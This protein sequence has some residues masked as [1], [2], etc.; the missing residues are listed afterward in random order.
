MYGLEAISANNGWA[1]AF[2]GA[3]IV[4][5]GL[6]FLSF[7]ISRLHK[8]LN[9][10]EERDMVYLRLKTM[11]RR[12]KKKTELDAKLEEHNPAETA[13]QFKM[14]AD[15]IGARFS[16]LNL[17]ELAEQRGLYRPHS[18]VN[19]LITAEVIQPDGKGF[20]LWNLQNYK[21]VIEEN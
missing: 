16:L 19:C 8:I 12:K 4:F 15:S 14:L 18:A 13:S 5:T 3:S 21:K 17:V 6:V 1:I 9:M 11:V 2:V 10:W 7:A 20:F